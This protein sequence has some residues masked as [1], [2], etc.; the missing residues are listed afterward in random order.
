MGYLT[1]YSMEA[2][3]VAAQDVEKIEAAIE[4]LNMPLGDFYYDSQYQV[5]NAEPNGEWRWYG[6][7]DDMAELSERF[8]GALFKLHGEGE[9]RDDVWDKYFAGG[10]MIEKVYVVMFMPEPKKVKWEA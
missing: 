9:N 8:P 7:E 2:L 6:H 1:S 4:E 3:H 10:E 5:F